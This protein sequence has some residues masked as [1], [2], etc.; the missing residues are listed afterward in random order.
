MLQR[1]EELAQGQQNQRGKNPMNHTAM[2]LPPE[3][4]MASLTGI[5]MYY[6]LHG[7]GHPLVMLHSFTESTQ[8]W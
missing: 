6:E 1:R 5:E 7:E 3:G 2:D 4:H 8:L